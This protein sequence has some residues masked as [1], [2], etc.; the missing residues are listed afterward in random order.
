M[1]DLEEATIEMIKS[2]ISIE[3]LPVIY[4]ASNYQNNYPSISGEV[5]IE[6]EFLPL[7]IKPMIKQSVLSKKRYDSVTESY[8]AMDLLNG[9][10]KNSLK[11]YI[12]MESSQV[13]IML[14]ELMNLVFA[15]NDFLHNKPSLIWVINREGLDFT[16]YKL[17][18]CQNGYEER[19]ELAIYEEDS[20]HFDVYAST[21]FYRNFGENEISDI[22]NG[23]KIFP[24]I[25]RDNS[26]D[27]KNFASFAVGNLIILGINYK[28]IVTSYDITIIKA[29][30]INIDLIETI[31]HQME[32]LENAFQ[33]TTN[34]LAR[35]AEANDDITGKHIKRVNCL[36]KKIAQ[37]L[38]LEEDFIQEIYNAAQMHDVGKIYVDKAILSKPGKLTQEEFEEMKKHT[39]YGE[40]IIGDSQ[41]LKM[42]AEIARSHHERYDGTGY[43]DG[44]A[45]ED[46]PLAARIVFLA[47]IYDALRSKRP[48]KIAFSHEETYKIIVEGDGRTMPFHFD[49]KVLE[50]FKNNHQEFD[51]IFCEFEDLE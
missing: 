1:E 11:K 46:I 12:K 22:D 15:E 18:L 31:R 47:D 32:D 40:K 13:K 9:E 24:R 21:G 14:K 5:I 45:G 43:P 28:D 41:Y 49:P 6:D 19:K 34:A 2:V 4:I 29:L 37:G 16:G 30:T 25:I 17:E 35:A 20:F 8:D 51:K 7:I 26:P 27:I 44:T 10:I 3:Y 50:V 36:A 48:Y 39:I 23:K 38:G 33:Y 42:S